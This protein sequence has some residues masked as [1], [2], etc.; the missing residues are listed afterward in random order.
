[1]IGWPWK[2]RLGEEWSSVGSVLWVSGTQPGVWETSGEEEEGRTAELTERVDVPG[3]GHRERKK[4]GASVRSA[5]TVMASGVKNPNKQT[6][7]ALSPS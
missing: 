1:M 2:E 3:D 5:G 6:P 7:V 4:Q